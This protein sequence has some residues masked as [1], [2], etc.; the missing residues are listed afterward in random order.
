M[1][2]I[3]ASAPGKIILFGEHAVVYHRPAIAVPIT[4][5]KAKA[6]ISANPRGVPGE[7]IIQA[8]NIS[9]EA[10]LEDL[11]QTNP[12]AAAVN[13]VMLHLGVSHIPACTIRITSSIPVASGLGS[14]AAVSVAVIRALSAFL[15]HPLPDEQVSKLAFDVEVLH[16]GTPSGIDNTVVTYSMPIFFKRGDPIETFPVKRPFTVVIADTSIPCP[17]SITVGEVRR[18][19]QTN[20]AKYEQIFDV[21]GELVYSARDAIEGGELK[22]LG[23]LMNSNHT[24]LQKLNVSSPDLDHL[25]NTALSAGAL[26]AKLSGGGRGGNMIALVKPEDAPALAMALIKEGASH[27]ITTEVRG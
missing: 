1:P 16:H 22:Q 2:A 18:A 3:S 11:P 4:E 6:I 27:T 21:I 15:G 10:Y 23:T 5:M 19:W 17:T 13:K 26:G 24:Y 20:P 7:V 8:P 25:V 12:L 14:G 9:L